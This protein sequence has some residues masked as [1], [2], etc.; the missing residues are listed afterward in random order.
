[1][2][3]IA[4]IG[5]HTAL[6]I[7][8][9]A[10]DEGF[11]T[12]V[13][14]TPLH[15][16]VYKEL[17][18]VADT[19]IEIEDYH[20]F[21]DIEQKLISE[22]AIIIPHGSFVAYLNHEAH[23][24]M[25]VRYFGNKD[26]LAWESDRKKQKQWLAEAGVK[27]PHVFEHHADIDRP[28]IVKFYGAGGG[29]GYFF[30]RNKDEFNA[31]VHKRK[32]D[33]SQVILQE[34]IVGCPVYIHYFYSLLDDR[35]E[36]MSLDRRYETT[37]DSLG[38]IPSQNQES[39][40][41]D[42]S[43]VVVGN[44]PLVLRESLLAKVYEMGRRV[45]DVSKK[46]CPAKGLYGAFCLETVATPEQEFYVI[47]LSARIVAGTNLYIN[48]SYYTD[49]VYDVPMSTGRRIALEIKRAMQQNRLDEIV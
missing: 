30:V 24:K 3:K 4:T 42:P 39:M 8:K 32:L 2:P 6:Q 10:K 16:K 15:Q 35:L 44:T 14:C 48:G 26:I 21:F 11:E 34:Y 49:L 9:G 7:L 43:F 37:V 12:I 18:P 36:I 23:K 31:E 5:S 41:L 19:V 20:K 22:D 38:R 45:V 28:T 27:L 17:F 1:M 47:E 25:R 29:R 46:L 33:T 40:L 13:V